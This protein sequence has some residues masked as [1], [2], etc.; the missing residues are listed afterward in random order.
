MQSLYNYEVCILLNK[1]WPVLNN[2]LHVR[3]EHASSQ[4]TLTVLLVLVTM[5]CQMVVASKILR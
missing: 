3:L 5:E 2:S 1:V 4:N